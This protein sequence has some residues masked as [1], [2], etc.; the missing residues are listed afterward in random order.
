MRIDKYL[1][2]TGI[3]PSRTYSKLACD[4]GYVKVNGRQAKASHNIKEGDEIEIDLPDRYIKVRVIEIPQ[5]KNIKKSERENFYE[6]LQ[7]V[8]KN[9]V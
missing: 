4:R 1:K 5:K 3:I 8:K 6:L 9:V 2:I 7:Y